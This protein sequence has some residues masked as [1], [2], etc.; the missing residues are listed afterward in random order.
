MLSIRRSLLFV[1]ALAVVIATAGCSV[2]G[3]SSSPTVTP[4]DVF[5]IVT[6]TPGTAPKAEKT[7]EVATSYVVQPGDNLLEIAVSFGVTIEALQK[8][9]DIEDPDSIFAGQRLVIPT[10]EN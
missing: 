2:R 8:P 9:N 6:P 1:C 5:V 4:D 7:N 3:K 10:P